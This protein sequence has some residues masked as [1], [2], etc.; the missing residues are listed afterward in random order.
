MAVDSPRPIS[1]LRGNLLLL[2][3]LLAEVSRMG[4]IGVG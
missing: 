4:K 2:L 3:T 1:R